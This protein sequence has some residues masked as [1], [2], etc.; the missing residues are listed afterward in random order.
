MSC[1]IIRCPVCGF[2][3]T[4][5]SVAGRGTLTVEATAW[6]QQCESPQGTEV[7]DC[8]H[9]DEAMMRFGFPPRRR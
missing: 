9:L 2:E 3:A 7:G 6:M 8:P 1:E 5:V 4:H